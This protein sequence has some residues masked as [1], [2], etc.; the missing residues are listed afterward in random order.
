MLP[1][2]NRN[3]KSGFIFLKRFCQ[4][5]SNVLY[6]LLRRCERQSGEAEM[7]SEIQERVK[8]EIEEAKNQKQEFNFYRENIIT[9]EQHIESLYEYIGYIGV[10]FRSG[11]F[12]EVDRALRR[13][14]L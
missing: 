7:I 2:R 13:I 8:N 9:K 3:E 11:N 4:K 14:N 6:F 1:I 10:N 12:E 5:M